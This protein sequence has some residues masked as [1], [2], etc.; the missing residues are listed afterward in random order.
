MV[1][2]PYEKI[3]EFLIN[4][5]TTGK[6]WVDPDQLNW[7]LY[8]A[9]SQSVLE[10]TSPITLPKAIKND[11]ELN[12]IRSCHIRDG[13]ALTAFLC[14]LEN[15]VVTDKEPFTE[16]MVTEKIEEFRKLD[17]KH[18]FPSFATIA[19]YGPNGAFM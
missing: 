2:H 12:G 7:R 4:L 19:G 8:K 15:R 10:K 16:Y 9:V 14:W 5:A 13:A 6:I 17:S 11:A 1:L 18:V 3:E